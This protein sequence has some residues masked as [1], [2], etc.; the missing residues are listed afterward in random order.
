MSEAQTAALLNIA[1][2]TVKSQASRA[3]RTLRQRLAADGRIPR[4]R[5]TG[6][7][8]PTTAA[9]ER[10]YATATEATADANPDAIQWIAEAEKD[11]VRAGNGSSI[12]AGGKR[13]AA[14]LSFRE[15]GTLTDTQALRG[16]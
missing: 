14:C 8:T 12:A 6:T 1:V 11:Q 16:A 13:F 5:K 15:T 7:P 9:P 4:A 2:G 3:L 10:D